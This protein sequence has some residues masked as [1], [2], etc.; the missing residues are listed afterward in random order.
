M[1]ENRI[2]N[3]RIKA[4]LNMKEMSNLFGIPYRTL[5]H[6]EGDARKPPIWAEKLILE[7]LQRIKMIK[8]ARKVKTP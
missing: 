1:E 3:A 4:G 2:K 6:W 7:K 8:T 5:Q